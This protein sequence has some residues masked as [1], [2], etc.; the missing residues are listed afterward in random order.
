MYAVSC[1]LACWRRTVYPG[2]G[3]WTAPIARRFHRGGRWVKAVPT[4]KIR[5]TSRR[6]P[7]RGTVCLAAVPVVATSGRKI[8][9]GRH[10]RPTFGKA[11]PVDAGMEE[12]FRVLGK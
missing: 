6:K 9:C 11:V 5:T 10:V 8:A 12:Y 3:T 1:H 4:V 2:G 7:S